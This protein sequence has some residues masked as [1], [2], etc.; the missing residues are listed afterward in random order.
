M[1]KHEQD[2]ER[3]TQQHVEQETAF[4]EKL[5]GILDWTIGL[6]AKF[7]IVREET[8][9]NWHEENQFCMITHD[10]NTCE[11]GAHSYVKEH[12]DQQTLFG[13]VG[14]RL[15]VLCRDLSVTDPTILSKT[16]YRH[17][18]RPDHPIGQDQ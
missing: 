15:T 2:E 17:E 4:L 16:F 3:C 18:K 6:Q 13:I 9:G 5:L 10:E 8:S 1:G 7:Q 12:A 11:E 14:E